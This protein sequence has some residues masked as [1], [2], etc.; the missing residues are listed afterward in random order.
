MPNI[1]YIDNEVHYT[2]DNFINWGLYGSLYNMIRGGFRKRGVDDPCR[3]DT[4]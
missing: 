4:R 1:N 2:A 3:N